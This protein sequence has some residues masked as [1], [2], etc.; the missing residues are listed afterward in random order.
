MSKGRI[1]GFDGGIL[2][3]NVSQMDNKFLT[4]INVVDFSNHFGVE[5][6]LL[7]MTLEENKSVK[8]E[9]FSMVFVNVNEGDV[10]YNNN[11]KSLMISGDFS[12]IDGVKRFSY[13]SVHPDSKVPVMFTVLNKNEVRN[14][15]SDINRLDNKSE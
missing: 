2:F 4:L 7:D 1:V 10:L 3:N 11:D 13:I 5:I 15:L 12:I 9:E 6:S 14:Y 8:P